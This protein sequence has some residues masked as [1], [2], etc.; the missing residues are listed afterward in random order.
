[1]ATLLQIEANRRN[2]SKSKGPTTPGVAVGERRPFGFGLK[3]P[4]DSTRS[5]PDLALLVQKHM[6]T[7]L[8]ALANRCNASDPRTPERAVGEYRQ[9]GVGW[10]S[11]EGSA[12]LPNLA[13]L[14]QKT[15][16]ILPP[17]SRR[18]SPTKNRPRESIRTPLEA[19]SE[20]L[21]TVRA[22]F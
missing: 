7:L 5:L 9:F 3:S 22:S 12:Q 14:V 1:M 17:T 6:A 15:M 4:E 16:A 19:R 18:A 21:T 10:K 11:P 20:T 8:L 13:L 2:A